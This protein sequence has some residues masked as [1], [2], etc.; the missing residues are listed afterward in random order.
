MNLGRF[1][2]EGLFLKTRVVQPRDV[3]GAGQAFSEK[4][5]YQL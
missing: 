4:L 5:S 3:L 2:V 1:L